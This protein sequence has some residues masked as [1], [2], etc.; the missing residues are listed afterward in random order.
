MKKGLVTGIVL[1]A[2]GIICGLLLATV[3]S[4]TQP[5]I[6]IQEEKIIEDNL[7]KIYPD[8]DSY[9]R[10]DQQFEDTPFADVKINLN[11]IN[12]STRAKVETIYYLHS[13]A[14]ESIQA[15]VYIIYAYGYGSD[16]VHMMIGVNKDGSIQGYEV[17]QQ[18][19]TPGYG[20]KIVGN[21]F[22]VSDINDLS[23]FDGI[24]GV[25]FSSKAV[26]ASFTIIQE[27]LDSDFGGGTN[28]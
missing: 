3:H 13:K 18:S 27:R 19:E 7:K 2:F 9:D 24:A 21:D 5:I 15:L 4:I 17:V 1:M 12:T 10:T 20:T 16:P 25:T 6:D 8:L 28:D 26:L 22:G 23:S 11:D 14:D